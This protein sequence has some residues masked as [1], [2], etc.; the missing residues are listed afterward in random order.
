MDFFATFIVRIWLMNLTCTLQNVCTEFLPTVARNCF[1][2]WLAEK[3]SGC[4]ARS[5]VLSSGEARS[6]PDGPCE[7]QDWQSEDDNK[8]YDKSNSNG[9]SLILRS[10]DPNLKSWIQGHSLQKFGFKTQR[11][12]IFKLKLGCLILLNPRKIILQIEWEFIM[13]CIPITLITFWEH[14]QI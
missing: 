10:Q 8:H 9:F 11:K 7:G 12:V 14:W 1:S 13:L 5:T 2:N 4:L 6:S 3:A